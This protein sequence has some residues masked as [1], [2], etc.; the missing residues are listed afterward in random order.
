MKSLWLEQGQ[1]SFRRDVP[2]PEPPDGEALIRVRVAGICGTDLELV[3]GY[4]PFS[5]IFGHEFVGEVVSAPDNPG[6]EGKRVVGEINAACGDC[7]FCREGIPTHC[8]RRTVL[9]IV[10]RDG[11]FADYLVLPVRN[12]HEVPDTIPDRRAV[13]TEPLAAALQILEQLEVLGGQKV[14]LIGAGRLGL[15]IAQVFSL[16]SVHLSVV[17]KHQS[18]KRLL[19]EWGIDPIDAAQIGER[20]WDVVIEATGSPGGLLQA[21]SAVR[22]RGTIVL[23]STY[24]GPATVDISRIVVDEVLLLGSRCGPFAPAL[25]LLEGDRIDTGS[26]VDG[27]LPLE[28]GLRALAAAAVPGALK[29]LLEMPD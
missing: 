24:A 12:L 17:A 3:K 4:Y 21:C 26:L 22:P 28:D 6:W 7:A 23:K 27:T 5:G 11:A 14:L 25:A 10:N 1:V 13:F 15:L 2:T 8:S 16:R 9:G 29:F 20:G 18:Q 19:S